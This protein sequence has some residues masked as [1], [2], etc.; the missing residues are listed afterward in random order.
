MAVRAAHAAAVLCRGLYAPSRGLLGM[1]PQ[2]T[3]TWQNTSPCTNT[4]FGAPSISVIDTNVEAI[5]LS[6]QLPP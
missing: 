2:S 4:S 3:G 6:S 5:T 1:V